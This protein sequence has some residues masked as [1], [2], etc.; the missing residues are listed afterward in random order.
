MTPPTFKSDHTYTTSE[1]TVQI[2]EE[3]EEKTEN[4][5]KETGPETLPK[6]YIKMALKAGA[7]KSDLATALKKMDCEP[8]IKNPIAWLQTA[9]EYEVINRELASRPKIKKVPK[10]ST[11]SHPTL[12]AKQSKTDPSKYDNFYL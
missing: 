1:T 2:Y 6:Q 8:D 7:N 4:I 12:T 9:L 5:Q 11:K 10:S 3:E